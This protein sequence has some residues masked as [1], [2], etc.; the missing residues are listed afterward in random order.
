MRSRRGNAA[1]ALVS[2]PLIVAASSVLAIAHAQPASS[3]AESPSRDTRANAPLSKPLGRPTS[4]APTPA[5]PAARG[6]QSEASRATVPRRART[7]ALPSVRSRTLTL[8]WEQETPTLERTLAEK[9]E[10]LWSDRPLRRGTTAIYVVDATT[11]RPLYA[12][13]EDERLNPASNVKLI[14][15]ATA[16]DVMGPDWRYV[17]RLLG[18]SP[19]AAGEVRGD[20][21]LVGSYDPTL[22]P[23]DLQ[24]MVASLAGRGVERIR[25]DLLVGEDPQRDGLNRATVRI[26]VEGGKAGEPPQVTVEPPFDL[27]EVEVEAKTVARRRRARIRIEGALVEDQTTGTAV[28]RYRLVVSG[29]ISAKRRATYRRQVPERQLFAA[30]VLRQALAEA[31]IEVTGAVRQTGLVDYVGTSVAGDFLPVELARHESESLRDLVTRINKRSLNRLADRVVMTAGAALY[32]GRP[33]MKKGIEAM[34]AW[35]RDR[36]GI[37]PAEVLVDTGSGLSYETELTARQ[38]VRV[39]RAASGRWQRTDDRSAHA[40]QEAEAQATVAAE[41]AAHAAAIHDEAAMQAAV[42]STPVSADDGADGMMDERAG[43]FLESLAVGGMDGTL[44]HRFRDLRG[45]VQAKTG[46][47]TSVIALSGIVAE[48]DGN[49]LAFSIVTNGNKHRKRNHVRRQHEEIVEALHRY[50]SARTQRVARKAAP[51]DGN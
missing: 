23:M 49:A 30:H 43:V 26:E 32:G 27:I 15:T 21:Y 25:G 16:L 22:H 47:L 20:V 14:A 24:A 45:K 28:P 4:P 51:D 11:G 19:D 41:V 35:L 46:T 5:H 3:P 18:P 48:G 2:A 44:R 33:S 8:G 6:K 37:D 36:A 9:I 10:A 42:A 31:G 13:H 38:I 34:H 40:D 39:L 50:L 29:T 1:L 17:T 7:V 12:V